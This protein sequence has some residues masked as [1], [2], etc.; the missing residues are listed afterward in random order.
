M[1]L[2]PRFCRERLD[3]ARLYLIFT[4]SRCRKDPLAVLDEV[5]EAG[6]DLV[7]VREPGVADR[8]L[9]EWVHDVRERTAIRR[10][11]LIVNDRPDIAI[12]A[13]AEG[14]H[15]GQGDLPPH[16]VRELVGPDLL[17]GYSTHD[18]VEVAE[19]EGEPVDY[20]GIGPIFDTDTKG[21]KGRGPEI[22]AE[23][24]P[25]TTRP[26]F[27]VGGID[28]GNLARAAASGLQ[29]AAVSAAVC[30]A[31]HPGTVVVALREALR[32]AATPR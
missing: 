6:V 9:L 11:P 31:V 3:E 1:T 21:L 26:A 15:V 13:G 32:D 24:L 17:V 22:L 25:H 23:L 4:R 5:L 16:A 10:V 8:E 19:A 2:D 28:L 12:L 27:G 18:R 29:R 20:I 7:Q 30:G 14:V